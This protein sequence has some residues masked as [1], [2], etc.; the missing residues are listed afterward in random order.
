MK[1]LAEKGAD[2]NALD[3]NKWTPLHYAA[4]CNNNA[5]TVKILVEKGADVNALTDNKWTALHCA[6]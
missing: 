2:V 4:W 1:I 5:E 6:A 3:Y